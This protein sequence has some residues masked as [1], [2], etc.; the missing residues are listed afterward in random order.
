MLKFVVTYV[1]HIHIYM[2]NLREGKKL[3]NSGVSQYLRT[4]RSLKARRFDLR[5]R[6]QL[7]PLISSGKSGG[8]GPGKG[9][10]QPIIA[11]LVWIYQYDKRAESRNKVVTTAD[12]IRFRRTNKIC[13]R[14]DRRPFDHLADR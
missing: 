11:A 4:T 1:T 8:W 14:A 3:A 13:I 6:P 5:K 10:A 2:E 9:R 12:S 7:D